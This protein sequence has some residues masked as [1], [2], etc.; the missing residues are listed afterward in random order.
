MN[1]IELLLF[2]HEPS[3][4]SKASLAGIDGFIIDWEDHSDI[5]RQ[6]PQ[7]HFQAPDTCDDLAR[8]TSLSQ[9]PVWCRINQLGSHTE[10]EIK[11]ALSHGADLILLPMVRQPE[12]VEHFL[13][14]IAGRAQTGILIE[15]VDACNC[16]AQLA[17]LPLDRVY[18]GLLDLAICR[19]SNDLFKP[20][21]DGTVEQLRNIFSE[22]S[23][24]VGGLTTV[25]AG[26]PVPCLELMAHLVRLGC[27]FTFLRNSF[28]RDVAGR[29][30]KEEISRIR[31]AWAQLNNVN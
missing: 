5:N 21:T 28:K 23:F 19:G 17:A 26:A 4:V 16:A 1:N 29:N 24:G 3:M 30:L 7:S 20:L 18:V 11:L 2:S 8:V 27:D 14:L 6:H 10:N 25:D 12:E 31:T 13:S 22:H 15:T 9:K